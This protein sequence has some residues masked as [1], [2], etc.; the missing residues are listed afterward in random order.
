VISPILSYLISANAERLFG[1]YKISIEILII[2]G[3]I[4]FMGLWLVSKR[5]EE[6][7]ET[8]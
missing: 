4:T 6:T 1:G 3:L 7:L 2:N 8:L 5:Q